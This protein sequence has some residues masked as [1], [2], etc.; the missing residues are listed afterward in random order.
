MSGKTLIN[1]RLSENFDKNQT[2]IAFWQK[3]L[4]PLH[5]L[6]YVLLFIQIVDGAQYLVRS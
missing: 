5:E 1:M 2:V 4:Y 6:I 3:D